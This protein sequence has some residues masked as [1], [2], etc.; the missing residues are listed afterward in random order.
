MAKVRT[1]NGEK[2]VIAKDKSVAST[3]GENRGPGRCCWIR[4]LRLLQ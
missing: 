1:C 4:S 3:T 2:T